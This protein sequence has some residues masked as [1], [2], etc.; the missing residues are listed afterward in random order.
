MGTVLLQVID[1]D[2]NPYPKVKS[3][4]EGFQSKH[5]DLW[6]LANQGLEELTAFEQNPPDLSQI[7]H[8][9]HP[10]DRTKINVQPA[11]QEENVVQE[12]SAEVAAVEGPSSEDVVG[13]SE[14]TGEGEPE[15]EGKDAAPA[16]SA[17]DAEAV[18]E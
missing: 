11:P 7:V 6:A 3:W 14:E 5:P 9:I 10:T 18:A 13:E 17:P 16:Q 1:Y 15:T 4:Y 12:I 8:P 2:L